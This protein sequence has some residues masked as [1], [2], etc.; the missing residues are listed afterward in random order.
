MLEE[1]KGD[2]NYPTSTKSKLLIRD[3]LKKILNK[4]DQE[5]PLCQLAE[6]I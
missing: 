6:D 1:E 2:N 3:K 5:H 4:M